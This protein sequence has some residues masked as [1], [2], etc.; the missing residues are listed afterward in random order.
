[1]RAIEPFQ[2]GYVDSRDGVRIAYE[3]FG[4]G[5]PTLVLLPSAPIVHSRQWKGQVPFL[6]RHYRVVTYDGRGNGR[7]D[8][9]AS[10]AAPVPR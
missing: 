8:R 2:A 7:S 4:A 9:P 5:D 1:M 10:S 6:S 3:V